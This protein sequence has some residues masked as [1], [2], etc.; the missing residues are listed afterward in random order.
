MYNIEIFDSLNASLVT[1]NDLRDMNAVN[2][3]I[4][5]F[6]NNELLHLEVNYQ[7]VLTAEQYAVQREVTLR[8]FVF[9]VLKVHKTFDG[10]S[11]LDKRDFD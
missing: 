9:R 5:R 11:F 8:R 3:Y 1:V 10:Y 7:D 6:L 2:E 4:V